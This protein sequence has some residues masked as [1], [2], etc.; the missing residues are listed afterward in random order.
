MNRE[1]MGELVG[2]I[3]SY[4][5]KIKAINEEVFLLSSDADKLI[6]NLCKVNND[7]YLLMIEDLK[8]KIGKMK[9]ILK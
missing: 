9:G 4:E 8:W 1:L 7:E 6:D 2:Q 3:V 5:R